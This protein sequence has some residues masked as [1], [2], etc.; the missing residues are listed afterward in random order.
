MRK[1]RKD[2]RSTVNVL[3][4]FFILSLKNLS[5]S[6]PYCAMPKPCAK[7][8]LRRSPESACPSEASSRRRARGWGAEPK[9]S[10]G[11][12]SF[13]N[14][15][16]YKISHTSPSSGEI[17]SSWYT[18]FM[19]KLFFHILFLWILWVL[20]AVLLAWAGFF[21][22]RALWIILFVMLAWLSH[23]HLFEKKQRNF[24]LSRIRTLPYTTV[25]LLGSL[26]FFILMNTFSFFQIQSFFTGRDQGSLSQASYYLS[27]KHDLTFSLKEALPFSTLYGEGKALN[28][29]GFFY[30]QTGDL[31]TQ[32]PHP[33][34]AWYASLQS[35]GIPSPFHI[36]LANSIT[37]F[38]FSIA[39]FLLV[40][41]FTSKNTAVL[42]TFLI[43]VT[44]PLWWFSRFSLSENLMLAITWSTLL[45]LML[46]VSQPS[47]SSFKPLFFA[48]LLLLITRIEGLLFTPLL[49]GGLFFFP[50]VRNF[51]KEHK[52]TFFFSLFTGITFFLLALSMNIPFYKTIVK[53]VLETLGIFPS[54]ENIPSVESLHFFELWGI[55]FLYGIG[56]LF[57]V[58]LLGLFFFRKNHLSFPPQFLFVIVILSPSLVYF[59]LPFISPDHPWMLRRF[60]FSALPLLVFI[61]AFFWHT[62]RKKNLHQSTKKITFFILILLFCAQ[63]IPFITLFPLRQ[64]KEL[65]Q[66]V[67]AFITGS[68]FRANDLLLVESAAT[69]DGFVMIPG[70]ARMEGFQSVYF[71]N[72]E[73]LSQLDF[74]SF[75]RVFLLVHKDGLDRYGD[76][77]DNKGL[78]LDFSDSRLSPSSRNNTLFSFPPLEPYT[79]STLLF[80]IY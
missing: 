65:F 6:S 61:L 79:S 15:L 8:G 46:F 38:L 27:Q 12:K 19:Q 43:L 53:A 26:C 29:P 69:G 23:Q 16:L 21:H 32:F 72:P 39:F 76:I 48:L 54:V 33:T 58:T 41:R 49:L 75:D 59:F 74:S 13:R 44:F 17:L 42:F 78:P 1:E 5:S 55:L 2:A 34:I 77:S 67:R 45:F 11:V 31:T 30:T 7:A 52:K 71:F 20:L 4:R 14:G 18:Y 57:L 56:I 73:D 47:L 70:I 50:Q 40:Q 60:M 80:R 63:I 62:V 64:D 37:L 66:Q 25:L 3:T 68:N 51:F 28:F 36:S 10:N 35:L 24:L 22:A 9:E